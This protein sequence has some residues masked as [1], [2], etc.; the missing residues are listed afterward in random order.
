MPAT[1][2]PRP[3]A[4]MR[5]SSMGCSC[6]TGIARPNQ[7]HSRLMTVKCHRPHRFS[8][9]KGTGR[10]RNPI[11]VPSFLFPSPTQLWFTRV[12]HLEMSRPDISDLDVG[13]GRSAPLLMKSLYLRPSPPLVFKWRF[14]HFGGVAAVSAAL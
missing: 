10:Y 6:A 9:R 2:K 13:E 11:E 4:S 12:G 3:S 14:R 5:M 7:R 1:K 8:R